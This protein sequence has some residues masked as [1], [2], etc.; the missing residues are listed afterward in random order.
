M[1]QIQNQT[2]TQKTQT[3]ALDPAKLDAF[4]GQVVGDAGAAMSAA[5]VVL[6]DRLGLYKALAQGPASAAELARRTGT[7]ERYIQEWLDAQAS[8]GYVRYLKETRTY[9]LP[10]EQVAALADELSPAFVPGMFQIM[11]AMWSAVDRMAEKFKNGDGHSWGDHHPCLFEGTER[12]FRSGYRGNLV[13]SWLPALDGAVTKL[14]RG[15]KVADVGCGLG[16]STILMAQAYPK[17]RFFGYDSHPASIE[18]AR[19]R[20]AE[21]GVAD[22]ITFEAAGATDF[23][24]RDYDLVCHFDCLHDMEDPTGAA[25]R[26]RE[27]LAKDGNWMIVEPF[28]ADL[29]ED[30]HNPIGRV[31]YSA[32]T[33]ICV[34]HSLSRRGPALGAQ[35]GEAR[36]GKI[37]SEAGFSRFRRATQTPFNLVLE[38]RV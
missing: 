31:F 30:N 14:E 7:A 12:F 37:I 21:A 34:P 38:A 22:R 33:M 8:G 16:A 15:A 24:G 3:P 1:T 23:P 26:V 28:A 9:E 19:R 5:L 11:Q 18:T 32:S 13:S 2:N 29:R 17:S 27:V 10:P 4:L 36:L 20:A 6:G 35:A 25:R